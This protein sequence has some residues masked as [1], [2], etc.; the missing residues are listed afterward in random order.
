MSSETGKSLRNILRDFI[1]SRRDAQN[2]QI[3]LQ[4]R[5]SGC[6]Q[7][8][9]KPCASRAFMLP[10]YPSQNRKTSS[11]LMFQYAVAAIAAPYGSTDNAA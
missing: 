4:P 11:G 8:L 3:D 7:H 2:N 6:Q 9:L 5:F 10:G 1:A